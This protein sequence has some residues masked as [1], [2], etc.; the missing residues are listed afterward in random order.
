MQDL[1]VNR[2]LD[3]IED[4]MLIRKLVDFACNGLT[5]SQSTE[6][7]VIEKLEPLIGSPLTPTYCQ[8]CTCNGKIE[9]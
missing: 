3:A 5:Q 8:F 4:H 1:T 7:C 2:I 6:L 9:K